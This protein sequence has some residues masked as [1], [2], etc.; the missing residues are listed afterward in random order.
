MAMERSFLTE[1]VIP[2]PI[3][4]YSTIEFALLSLSLVRLDLHTTHIYVK[5]PNSL[6]RSDSGN[7]PQRGLAAGPFRFV[8]Q[9]TQDGLR[10]R[11]RETTN[12]TYPIRN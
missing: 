5:F 1:L 9:G 8:V 3:Q 4:L 12:S 11:L 6:C 10:C 7:F 2:F